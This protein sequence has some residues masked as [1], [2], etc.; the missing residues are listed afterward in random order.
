MKIKVTDLKKQLKDYEQKD[1][2]QL[3]ADLYKSSKEVQTYLSIRFLGEEAIIELF[4][5][6]KK[7]IENEFFPDRGHGKLRLNQAKNAISHFNKLTKDE[8]RT[9]DLM[10]YYVEQGVE[11]TNA[12]GDI[13]E[14]FYNSMEKMYE[15]VT[16]MCDK[17]EKYYHAFADRLEQ[18]V[19]DTDGIGWGFH[20]QLSY[21]YSQMDH[22]N[23]DEE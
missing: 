13:D 1:L 19:I 6:T 12:F 7:T 18:V 17:E 10:L 2:I 5:Q 20:D 4:N 21:L 11:F 15:K 22:V 16:I 14:S 23:E 9:T 8:L 3:I